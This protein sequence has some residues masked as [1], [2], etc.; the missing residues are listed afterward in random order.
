MFKIGIF[1]MFLILVL[2]ATFIV[3]FIL[4]A[5]RLIKCKISVN[6]KIFWLVIMLLFDVVGAVV[7][8]I[9]HDFILNPEMR[10][11]NQNY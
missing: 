7:F 4:I 10:A 8:F 11:N 1:E 6:Q 9:Y 2:A 5:K 3:V